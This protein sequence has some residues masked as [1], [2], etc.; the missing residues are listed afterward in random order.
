MKNKNGIT[1]IALV[2]TIIVLLILAGVTISLIIGQN[3][4][5][6]KTNEAKEATKEGQAREE[7]SLAWLDTQTEKVTN[8]L[9]EKTVRDYFEEELRK[10]DENAV[11]R[12][13]GDNYEVTYK[14][15]NAVVNDKGEITIPKEVKEI[16]NII[17][18]FTGFLNVTYI[19]NDQGKVFTANLKQGENINII[20]NT[21]PKVE[22][23]ITNKIVAIDENMAL[24]NQ[25]KVYTWG[26]NYNGQ[27]GAGSDMEYS[28]VP[29][30]ISDIEGNALN[31]K[32]II[33]I[34]E[35][36]ALDDQG[37]VYTW[38]TDN[39]GQLGLDISMGCSYVPICISDIEGNA[40]NGKK[41]IAIDNQIALDDQGKVYTWG[42]NYNG[43]LGAG[44]DGSFSDGPICI[45]NIGG[46][47][48]NGKKVIAINQYTALDE[49]GKV[50]T[51]GLNRNGSLGDGT[52]ENSNIPICISDIEGNILKGK[53]IVYAGWGI[54]LDNQGKVY[55]W[56]YNAEGQLGDGTTN[57]S[58]IPICISD[59]ESSKLYNKKVRKI[60]HTNTNTII[61]EDNVVYVFGYYNPQPA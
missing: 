56:G 20:D 61:G 10:K 49:Q 1:L 33:A 19:L 3:G 47:T 46:N 25:G 41:V 55:T 53:Q 28:S 52:N 11:V 16:G 35:G 39:Q 18:A 32:R 21:Y 12:Q 29:I 15:Y 40:L 6:G 54:A 34:N 22:L 26:S 37:K 8:R 50:Y 7:I 43:Q 24:D 17:D 5:I 51:W 36:M 57:N 42:S 14:G 2:V 31:G 48:L 30:C 27:L 38:G 58:N 4:I 13:T 59:M 60:R 9:G 44:S 45:S 23:P